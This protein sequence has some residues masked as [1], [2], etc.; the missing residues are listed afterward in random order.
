MQVL[1]MMAQQRSVYTHRIL[2]DNPFVHF[3]ELFCIRPVHVELRKVNITR[4]KQ[5]WKFDNVI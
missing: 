3:K 4:E 2:R 1:A 5:K